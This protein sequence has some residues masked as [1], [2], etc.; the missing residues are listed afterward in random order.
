MD[1]TLVV[2]GSG[3]IGSN[4]QRKV[5]ENHCENLFTFSFNDQPEKINSNLEK[6]HL[7]LLKAESKHIEDYSTALYVAGNADHGLAKRD[8]LLDLDLN[9]RAFLKFMDQFRGSLILLSSQAVY[10]G[11]EGEIHEK[12]DHV[13]AMPYGLSKQM[14]ESYAKYFLIDGRLSK[15]W[16]FRLAYAFGGGEKAYRLIPRCAKA[17]REKGKVTLFG[18]G[19][20]F[21]NPLPAEFVAETLLSASESLK[22]KKNG[23]LEITNLNHPKRT[24][25]KDVIFFLNCLK[26]FDFEAKD[27]GEEW[28]VKFYGNTENLA[29]HLKEWNKG[30]PDLQDSLKNYFEELIQGK[31]HD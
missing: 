24:T 5:L 22:N 4:I 17:V 2:G 26:R 18:G 10:Y 8:P 3:F 19:N 28:P 6:F 23:I 11:L 7:D 9:A 25:V 14:V 12:V 13:S 30:F 16:V 21:I 20:S 29:N 15:L 1:K 31:K 27:S